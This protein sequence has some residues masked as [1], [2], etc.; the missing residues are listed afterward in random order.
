MSPPTSGARALRVATGLVGAGLA[1][2][3]IALFLWP[4]RSFSVTVPERVPVLAESGGLDKGLGPT[5]RTEVQRR[6]V[7]CSPPS[8]LFADDE[9]R[10]CRHE[11]DRR[12]RRSGAGLALFATGGFVY[13]VSGLEPRRRSSGG[14]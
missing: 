13:V 14:Q 9:P 6:D 7:D 5:G 4:L 3:G 12:L 10:V 2:A 8:R 11:D 1:V